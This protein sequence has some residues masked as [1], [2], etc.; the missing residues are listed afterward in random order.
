MGARKALLAYRSWGGR[1]DPLPLHALIYMAL[2]SPDADSQALYWAGSDAIAVNVLGREEPLTDADRLA[3]KRLL[4]KLRN[5]GA[6]KL[7]RHSAPGRQARYAL[8]LDAY[9]GR[10]AIPEQG[11]LSDPCNT[12]RSV[13]PVNANRYHSVTQTGVAERPPEEEEEEL[14]AGMRETHK[15]TAGGPADAAGPGS[16]TIA[17]SKPKPKRFNIRKIVAATWDR[18]AEADGDFDGRLDADGIDLDIYDRTRRVL[19]DDGEYHSEPDPAS[20]HEAFR[21]MLRAMK[22]LTRDRLSSNVPEKLRYELRDVCD[23]INAWLDG[24][25]SEGL[26]MEIE[27]AL[28]KRRQLRKQASKPA[29][30]PAAPKRQPEPEPQQRQPALTYCPQCDRQVSVCAHISQA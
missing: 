3:V 4:A 29:P 25:D 14:K 17:A 24:G 9:R 21:E 23:D 10:S 1:I 8:S 5:A 30:T 19:G 26:P 2:R 11:S 22:L 12:D 16:E 18:L 27:Q 15:H 13:I 20:L 6:I 7:D 28:A